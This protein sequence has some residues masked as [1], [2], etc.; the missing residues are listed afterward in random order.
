MNQIKSPFT[1]EQVD[2]LN[3]YQQK[4]MFHPFTCDRKAQECEV[5]VSPRDYT[6][7]GIL[8]ATEQGWICPCGKYTQNWCHS[9]MSDKNEKSL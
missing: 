7:D 2:N 6:K 4:G 5:N 1:K 8:I 9:F 3:E